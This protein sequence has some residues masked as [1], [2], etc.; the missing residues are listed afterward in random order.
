MKIP[1]EE[2]KK[3]QSLLCLTF[4]RDNWNS[5]HMLESMLSSLPYGGFGMKSGFFLRSLAHVFF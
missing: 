5:A 2:E 4:P 3:H 1:E